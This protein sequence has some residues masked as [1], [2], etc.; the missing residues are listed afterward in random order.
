VSINREVLKNTLKGRNCGTCARSRLRTDKTLWTLVRNAKGKLVK[1]KSKWCEVMD[2]APNAG[3]CQQWKMTY[4][5]RTVK[6]FKHKM[7]KR[8]K[9]NANRKERTEVTL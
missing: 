8:E 6:N 5:L 1:E 2:H 3:V 4:R 7:A 9:R